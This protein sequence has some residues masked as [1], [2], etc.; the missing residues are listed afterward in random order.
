MDKPGTSYS[1]AYKYVGN[2]SHEIGNGVSNFGVEAT[3]LFVCEWCGGVV[4]ATDRHD[5]FHNEVRG[6]YA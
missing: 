1:P 2:I 4:A 6:I 3:D 5:R